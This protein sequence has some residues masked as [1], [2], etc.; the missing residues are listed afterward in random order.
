MLTNFFYLVIY[1]TFLFG[2]VPLVSVVLGSASG[3]LLYSI[4]L[5]GP[6]ILQPLDDEYFVLKFSGDLVK[7][8][9]LCYLCVLFL[10]R[11]LQHE[12]YYFRLK[13]KFISRICS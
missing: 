2:I 6:L 7:V 13:W 1:V 11:G 8:D 5:N 4:A 3:L 10:Y 12:F 9:Q